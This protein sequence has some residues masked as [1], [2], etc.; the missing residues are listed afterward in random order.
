[1][2]FRFELEVVNNPRGPRIAYYCVV[3][4]PGSRYSVPVPAL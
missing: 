2:N 4:V 3:R 1:M